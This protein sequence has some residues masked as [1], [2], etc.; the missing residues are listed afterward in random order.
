MRDKKANKKQC[1]VL[2]VMIRDTSNRVMSSYMVGD[3]LVIETEDNEKCFV[4]KNGD[5]HPKLYYIQKACLP[6]DACEHTGWK[7]VDIARNRTQAKEFR[8]HWQRY[9]TKSI[10][11]R[12]KP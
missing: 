2:N 12:I 1:A 11:V 10:K 4:T 5:K 6:C 8:K 3:N 9:F 7:N